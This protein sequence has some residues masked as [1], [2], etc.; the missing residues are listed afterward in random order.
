MRLGMFLIGAAGVTLATTGRLSSMYWAGTHPW[1]S[2]VVEGV[3]WVSLLYGAGMGGYMTWA[4]K[5]GK[6]RTRDH[7]LELSGNMRPWRCNKVVLDV[8][9][10]RGLMLIGAAKLLEHGVAIGIDPWRAEDQ[11]DNSPG[12]AL[13]NARS[14]GVGSRVQITTGDARNLPFGAGTVDIV[15]S[16]WVI[17]NLEHEADRRTALEEMWRVLRPGGL[18]VLADIAYVSFYLAH[19][20]ALGAQEC[21]LLD[22][23]WEAR[24]MGALSGGTYRPQAFVCQRDN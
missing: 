15:L 5:I 2:S 6:R 11:M 4:S 7:L 24:I 3:G 9:C 13:A 18:M 8:G 23:G 22:G 16:H 21:T 12:A 10:G 14:E 17:H 1:L 19:L 20:N